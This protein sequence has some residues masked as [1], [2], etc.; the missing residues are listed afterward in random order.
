M[1]TEGSE[2]ASI[3]PDSEALYP[4]RYSVAYPKE[5][6]RSKGVQRGIGAFI[7]WVIPFGLGYLSYSLYIG[8]WVVFASLITTGVIGLPLYVAYKMRSKGRQRFLEE[9]GRT[10]EGVARWALSATAYALFMT[11][12]SPREAM[13]RS[14][15]L[16]IQSGGNVSWIHSATTPVLLLPHILLLALF[17]FAF[18]VIV[19]VCVVISIVFKCYPGWIF[20]FTSGYLCWI[21]RALGY[22]ISLTDQYPPF[23]FRAD[24]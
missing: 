12:D 3:N 17:G 4:I 1:T 16:E 21:A 7:S 18:V 15:R 19:P 10:L 24:I 20:G 22:W 8:W 14:V 11:D 2:V 5:L 13:D 6:S 23:S 9:D